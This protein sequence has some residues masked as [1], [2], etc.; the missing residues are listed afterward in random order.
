MFNE[1]GAIRPPARSGALLVPIWG[2]RFVS[3]FLEFGLPTLPGLGM[4]LD[5]AKIE[6]QTDVFAE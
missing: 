6:I 2:Y 3:Q 1:S 5:P 4:D